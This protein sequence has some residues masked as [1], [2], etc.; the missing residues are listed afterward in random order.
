MTSPLFS[1]IVTTYNRPEFLREAVESVLTQTDPRFEVL[2]VDDASP[3]PLPP[4]PNDD[5]VS[6]IIRR[7]NG[8]CSAARNTG[9]EA[10]RGEWITFLD[11]DDLLRPTRLADTE[12]LLTEAPI[13]V[14][15]AEHVDGERAPGHRILDGY[16]HDCILDDYTPHVG[17]TMVHRDH[18]LPF[19]EDYFASQDLEWWLRSSRGLSVKTV[20]K[21]GYLIRRHPGIRHLNGIEQRIRFSKQLL[22]DFPEYFAEHKH[23]AGFREWRIGSM[24]MTV[25]DLR[26]ARSALA[27][28]LI[29]RPR[30]GTLRRLLSATRG[31][32]WTKRQ[33]D[34]GG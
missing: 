10:A 19:N 9:I 27:R 33:E 14:C 34:V 15:W 29:H 30:V 20:P 7:E 5:R 31:S 1:V 24:S 8:G 18:L 25:G 32:I 23:A 16:V 28:S 22:N 17:A 3:V 26:T 21:V 2:V 13:V 11:D 4:L 12:E 6:L